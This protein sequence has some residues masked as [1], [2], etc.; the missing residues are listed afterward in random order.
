MTEEERKLLHEME[1]RDQN[2]I[3]FIDVVLGEGLT[4]RV[5]IQE[6]D[7]PET[8]ARYVCLKYKIKDESKLKLLSQMLAQQM[9]SV[10][11][12]VKEMPD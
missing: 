2:T 11:E 5:I 3:L 9:S 8:L 12:S 7:S 4:E 1:N 6:G 10:L